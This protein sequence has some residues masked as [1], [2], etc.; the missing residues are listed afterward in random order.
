M[1]V[2]S[3]MAAANSMLLQ[4]RQNMVAASLQHIAGI[5]FAAFLLTHQAGCCAGIAWAAAYIRCHAIEDQLEWLM[6]APAGDEPQIDSYLAC[7]TLLLHSMQ[8]AFYK[9]SNKDYLL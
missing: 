9:A 3:D 7:M 4:S 1:I 6:G 8:V 2:S 5:C